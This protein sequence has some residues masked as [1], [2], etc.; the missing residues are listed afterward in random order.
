M[1]KRPC[2]DEDCLTK[3]TTAMLTLVV[4]MFSTFLL[5]LAVNYE[6]PAIKEKT[7][8]CV[9]TESQPQEKTQPVEVIR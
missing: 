9:C 8:T 5:I 4:F 6:G 3:V 7:C 1:I 2:F